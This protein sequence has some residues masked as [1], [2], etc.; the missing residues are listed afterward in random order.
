M[1]SVLNDGGPA[2]A[3]ALGRIFSSRYFLS[4][5]HPTPTS[6][7]VGIKTHSTNC[8]SMASNCHPS[9]WAQ[10]VHTEPTAWLHK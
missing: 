5:R 2:D 9:N 3:S 8:H 10:I 4:W 7:E 6:I 1:A